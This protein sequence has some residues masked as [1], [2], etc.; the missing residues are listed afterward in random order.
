MGTRKQELLVLLTPRILNRGGLPQPAPGVAPRGPSGVPNSGPMPGPSPFAGPGGPGPA[1]VPSPIDP[2]LMTQ[3]LDRQKGESAGARIR[4]LLSAD[5]DAESLIPP[6][7]T[8]PAGPVAAGTMPPAGPAPRMAPGG[9]QMPQ[10]GAFQPTSYVRPTSGP[11]AVAGL[12]E[13]HN[14]PPGDRQDRGNRGD[15]QNRDG[16]QDRGYRPGDLTRT[17]VGR[18]ARRFG[19]D[20]D[21]AS[22][23]PQRIAPPADGAV[24]RVGITQHVA[25]EGE[26]F[27]SI[28]RRYYGTPALG[29]ALWA[30]NRHH[31][32]APEDL[33]PGMTLL[34]PPVE[35]LER[36]SRDAIEATVR[37]QDPAPS[38][39]PD[40]P[41]RRW[42]GRFREDP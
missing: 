36:V 20:E 16:Q 40:P 24:T 23:A 41:R 28:A 22:T 2:A 1:A 14:E 11:D 10:D 3:R 18:L 27:R 29:A 6:N 15:R 12:L 42:L 37:L 17:V 30:V 39:R 35:V 26:D 9:P 38:G 21:G 19:R 33:G 8:S 32:Q 5:F 4:A 31:V 25:A 7:F 13:A 34:V